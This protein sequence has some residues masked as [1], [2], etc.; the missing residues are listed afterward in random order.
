ML[1]E[2]NSQFMEELASAY[3]YL[4][5][6]AYFEA[7][8]YKGFATWMRVQANEEFEHAMKFYD[9]IFSRGGKVSMKSLSEPQGEWDSPLAAF[10]AALEHE[11]YISDR[12]NK[13]MDLAIEEKDHATRD[14]L[15]WFVNEQVE[16]ENS[17]MDIVAMMEK[18]GDSEQGLFFLDQKLGERTDSSESEE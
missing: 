10:K 11:Q 9:Y 5:M 12:I 1:E 16:E 4:S 8:N 17:V 3:L 2:L 6:S 7:E 15:D 14:F 13:L 18:I